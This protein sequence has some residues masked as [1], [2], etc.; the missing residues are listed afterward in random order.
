MFLHFTEVNVK[1]LRLY[2]PH[3]LPRLLTHVSEL[4]LH[5]HNLIKFNDNESCHSVHLNAPAPVLSCAHTCSSFNPY[6]GLPHGLPHCGCVEESLIFFFQHTHTHTHTSWETW[7]VF[8][9]INSLPSVFSIQ[10]RK[11][12]RWKNWMFKQPKNK[13]TKE[14]LDETEGV[15]ENMGDTAKTS[16]TPPP[17]W[18]CPRQPRLVT[19]SFSDSLS[20]APYLGPLRAGV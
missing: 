5:Q 6:S 16:H 2:L 15:I 14:K 7:Q 9:L 18:H 19:T 20:L 12:G 4:S 10:E 8:S 3:H 1:R 13:V 17:W 11:A